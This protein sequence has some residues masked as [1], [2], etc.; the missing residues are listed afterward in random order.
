MDK[1]CDYCGKLAPAKL[2]HNS[3]CP[4]CIHRHFA[5]KAETAANKAREEREAK[6]I[7]AYKQSFMVG[8][9]SYNATGQKQRIWYGLFP[10]YSD[11]Y[12]AIE[13]VY[14][15]SNDI[16]EWIEIEMRGDF[17]FD[18][19]SPEELEVDLTL[20]KIKAE[21]RKAIERPDSPNHAKAMQERRIK[22][23]ARIALSRVLKRHKGP[24]KEVRG[25]GLQ[26]SVP[27]NV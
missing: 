27:S 2:M 5:K 19:R 17:K 21:K 8:T 16:P 4:T 12:K 22:E 6:E 26:H 23:A 25:E 3:L 9:I 10:T 1:V 13:R 24:L 11:V 20:S 15:H 7:K 14:P 18:L